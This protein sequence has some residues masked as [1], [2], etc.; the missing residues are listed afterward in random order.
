MGFRQGQCLRPTTSKGTTRIAESTST[1]QLGTSHKTCL[2]GFGGYRS[3]AW[4]SAVS[5]VGRTSNA[6][7]VTVKLQTFLFQM[8]VTS[9]ISV[10]YLWKYGFAKS[11]DNIIRTLRI[12]VEFREPLWWPLSCF[13]LRTQNSLS[14]CRHFS[15]TSTAALPATILVV[16]SSSRRLQN[17]FWISSHVNWISECRLVF[18]K[19]VF[20]TTFDHPCSF[21]T[22]LQLLLF[23][24]HSFANVRVC[25]DCVAVSVLMS[26]N[27]TTR[28]EVYNYVC[29]LL[30]LF[31]V[32]KGWQKF[33][34][35]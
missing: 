31:L 1:Q 20:A 9:C 21:C 30:I 5:H 35:N 32:S 26:W 23:S 25:W 24:G 11:S 12:F 34:T 18:F 19:S 2:R 14:C 15:A 8:V 10:H 7:K 27:V 6:F 13:N 16:V 29:P 33:T 28:C 17:T 4:T 22:Y 3:I